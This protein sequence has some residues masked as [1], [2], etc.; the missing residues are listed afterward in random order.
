MNSIHTR[1]SILIAG[2]SVTF[3]ILAFIHYNL[4]Y[5]FNAE[6]YFSNGINLILSGAFGFFFIWLS[7]YFMNNKKVSKDYFS[8]QNIYQ[9]PEAPYIEDGTHPLEAELLCLIS[10]H[11]NWPVADSHL[12]DKTLKNV[13]VSLWER[14]KSVPKATHLYRIIALSLHICSLKCFEEVRKQSKPWQFWKRDNIKFVSLSGRKNNLSL[15]I[16]KSLPSYA[17]LTH[18]DQEIIAHALTFYGK[19]KPNNFHP[20]SEKILNFLSEK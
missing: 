6:T 18:K 7:Q 19:E 3:I 17:H 11:A 13:A 1:I 10:R 5:N 16:V 4:G 20:E 15:H 9:I 12:Q 14:T 2:F 8:E